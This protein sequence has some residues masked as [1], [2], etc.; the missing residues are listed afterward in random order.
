MIH[1]IYDKIVDAQIV[2]LLICNVL[3]DIHIEIFFVFVEYQL[4]VKISWC[5]PHGS[6][7][8]DGGAQ[9]MLMP[10]WP[11]ASVNALV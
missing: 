9:T 3:I 8:R 2:L 6:E 7:I 4:C 5:V 11:I 10:K 1:Q